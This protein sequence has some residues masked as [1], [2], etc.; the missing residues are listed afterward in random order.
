VREAKTLLEQH[1]VDAMSMGRLAARFRLS[2]KHFR[3]IFKAHT[4]LSP[5]QYYLQL[6]IHR[7]QEML[8]GTTLSVKEIAASLHFENPFHFSNVFKQKTGMS[9]SR[10]RSGGTS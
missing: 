3:R 8:L 9:P 2:E 10:W 5:Y 6:R 4:G 1:A 7:A